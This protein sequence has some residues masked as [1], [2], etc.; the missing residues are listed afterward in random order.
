MTIL[1]LF[2]LLFLLQ[3]DD[4]PDWVNVGSG[5]DLTIRE[6]AEQVQ[7]AVG[8]QCALRFDTSMP[9]GAPRKLCD[10]TLIRS[11][12]WRPEIPLPDGLKRTVAEYRA[13][14]AADTLRGN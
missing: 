5:E 8:S 4:P 13:E 9:D 1:F 12:G 2:A 14:L 10:T 3:L 6:L 7:A 11:L